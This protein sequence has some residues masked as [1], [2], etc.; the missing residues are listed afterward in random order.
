MTS[1]NHT[2]GTDRVAEVVKKE[3]EAEIIINIQGDEPLIDPGLIDGLVNLFKDNKVEMGTIIS[4]KITV[5]ELLDKNIVKAIL[6]EKQNIKDFKRNV[7]D[8]EIGAV[9]RHIGIYAYTRDAL[10]KFQSF[11]PSDREIEKSLEQLRALDNGIKIRGLITNCDQIAVDTEEDLSRV[12][13][14]MG[15]VENL[16]NRDE[17]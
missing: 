14:R 15:I 1:K 2:S 17:K 5:S 8:I 12:K 7:Y 3:S 13:D 16:D 9:Y 4:R 11:K 6:D 10:F